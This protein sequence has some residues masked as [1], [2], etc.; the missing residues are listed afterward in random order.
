MW[1]GREPWL[2]DIKL[3]GEGEDVIPLTIGGV[4]FPHNRPVNA[5]GPNTKHLSLLV[6]DFL[7]LELCGETILQDYLVVCKIHWKHL[8]QGQIGHSL[9][10]VFD[11]A[12][13]FT[14]LSLDLVP[15]HGQ[16]GVCHQDPLG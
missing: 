7:Q 2:E 9:F 12:S 16:R 3:K 6:L 8:V 10:Q 1:L 14:H 13:S 11:F 4:L 5:K 15:D